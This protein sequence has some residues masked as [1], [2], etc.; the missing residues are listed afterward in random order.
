MALTVALRHY[1]PKA[2]VRLH[3]RHRFP[4]ILSAENFWHKRRKSKRGISLAP[5]SSILFLE[6]DANA[7]IVV[8][9]SFI[10]SWCGISILSGIK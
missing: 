2:P 1:V 10:F 6:W 9:R 7:K 5:Q 4:S 8:K 3:K